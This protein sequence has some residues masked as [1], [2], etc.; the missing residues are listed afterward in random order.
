MPNYKVVF[1][2]EVDAD[3]P[4]EAAKKVQEWLRKDNWQ[5]YI[6]NDETEEIFSVDLTEIDS[7]AVLP[8]HVYHPMIE[9]KK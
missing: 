7:D 8:V 1:E 6:Q 5:W 9:N 2:I 4:I 3:F